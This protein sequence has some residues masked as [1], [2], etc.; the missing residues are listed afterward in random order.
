MQL[1]KVSLPY[2]AYKESNEQLLMQAASSNN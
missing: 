1:I 2:L